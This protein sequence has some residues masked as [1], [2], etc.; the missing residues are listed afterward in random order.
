MF[1]DS[2]SVGVG[3]GDDVFAFVARVVLDERLADMGVVREPKKCGARG[4]IVKGAAS[5][6]IDSS[7]WPDNI[8]VNVRSWHWVK[9]STI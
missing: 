2:E 1:T 9:W 6:A 7:P 8:R 3:G 5:E 4:S